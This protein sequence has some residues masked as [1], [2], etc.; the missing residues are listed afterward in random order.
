MPADRPDETAE[1]TAHLAAVARPQDHRH[2]TTGGG[3]VDVDR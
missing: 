2:R 3:I 1:V